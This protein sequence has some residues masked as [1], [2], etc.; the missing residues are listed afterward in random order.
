[1]EKKRPASITRL[2]WVFIIISIINPPLA[3]FYI[4]IGIG[5]LKL[6][7]TSRTWGVIAQWV[8]FVLSIIGVL[9]GVFLQF[10]GLSLLGLANGL[11]AGIILYYL[12]HPKI[13]EQFKGD[14]NFKI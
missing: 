7:E 9:L 1:M 10:L 5:I 4:P 8:Q 11:L 12:R 13:K 2:G 14:L 6:R 3:L